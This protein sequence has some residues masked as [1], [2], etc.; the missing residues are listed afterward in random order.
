MQN[1]DLS[2]ENQVVMDTIFVLLLQ[3]YTV[4]KAQMPI[5]LQLED[6]ISFVRLFSNHE[7]TECIDK[8]IQLRFQG[9]IQ[10]MAQICGTFEKVVF[11]LHQEPNK[12]E[13]ITT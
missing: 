4:K 5:D 3:L 11:S 12:A 6:Y 9:K 1:V 13:I 8:Y 10:E 2:H 7:E